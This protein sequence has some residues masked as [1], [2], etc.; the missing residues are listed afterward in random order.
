MLRTASLFAAAAAFGVTGPANAQQHSGQHATATTTP[1]IKR[2]PLQKFDVP[3]TSH[4]AVIGLAESRP[5]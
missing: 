5:T 4:E 3:G 1:A 2:T